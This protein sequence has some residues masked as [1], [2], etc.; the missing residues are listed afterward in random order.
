MTLDCP[1]N[2]EASLVCPTCGVSFQRQD[3]LKRHVLLH[4]GH[5]PFVCS[6]CTRRFPRRDTLQRHL[7]THQPA[8]ARQLD[9]AAGKG[10][11]DKACTSCRDSK[12]RCNGALPCQRCAKKQQP[13]SYPSRQP[14]PAARAR[15][16]HV[17]PQPQPQQS[18]A[19]STGSGGDTQPPSYR[20]TTDS[21]DG[22]SLEGAGGGV[23]SPA[24]QAE[25]TTS[26][27]VPWLQLPSLDPTALPWS[28]HTGP[29]AF[30][31]DFEVDGPPFLSDWA[32]PDLRTIFSLFP[33]AEPAQRRRESTFPHSPSAATGLAPPAHGSGAPAKN[34]GP[35][36][37]CPDIATAGIDLEDFAN[38][39]TLPVAVY[40]ATVAWIQSLQSCETDLADGPRSTPNSEATLKIPP[41]DLLNVFVQL[42]FEYFHDCLPILHLPTFD[43]GIAPPLMLLAIARI[44]SRLSK[45]PAAS[46]Y[47]PSLERLVQAGVQSEAAKT[48]GLGGEHQLWLVQ[49]AILAHFDAVFG[50]HRNTLGKA[51]ANGP[52]LG[53]LRQRLDYQGNEANSTG[54]ATEAADPDPSSWHEWIELEGTRRTAFAL[55]MLDSQCNLLLDLP[56]S[57]Q[58]EPLGQLPCHEDIWAAPN[59]DIWSDRWK[60]RYHPASM[61]SEMGSIYRGNQLPDGI[62]A[63]SFLLLLLCFFRDGQRLKQAWEIGLPA[64]IAKDGYVI[65]YEETLKDLKLWEIL[66]PGERIGEGPMDSVIFQTYQLV[67][68]LNLVPLQDLYSFCGWDGTTRRA[69]RRRIE[70]RQEAWIASNRGRKARTVA[71]RAGRLYSYCLARG[72]LT[73][74]YLE[75]RSMLIA[76]LA[77][78][79]YVSA[80]L[81]P[82]RGAGAGPFGRCAT[83]PDAEHD[84]GGGVRHHQQQQQQL[85]EETRMVRLDKPV[86]DS[87]TVEDWVTNGCHFRCFVGGLGNI[88]GRKHLRPVMIS[89][90][91]DYCASL[92]H[93]Q[94]GP[95]IAKELT[96]WHE[97]AEAC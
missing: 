35:A 28:P 84:D 13:C 26:G 88:H 78:W 7:A 63:F 59:A 31:A 72:T 29:G 71:L 66:N 52:T 30:S 2:E 4:D 62:G 24:R 19:A 53:H 39:P 96:R 67:V 11:S 5:K 94:V 85:H 92:Q 89:N 82:D 27:G 74:G 40:D 12:Q 32:S 41:R 34:S 83:T 76:T 55:W 38:V 9:T 73:R 25:S 70:A 20:H 43:P 64:M 87:R 97:C 90:A 47:G 58:T 93:W 8:E 68:V 61:R 45:I 54:S 15:Q 60:R 86:V 17:S 50:N 69:G 44:G 79:A 3:H 56:P 91:A 36:P 95:A 37:P 33:D 80:P 6:F 81:T 10:R 42:Y 18:P 49:A 21:A 46:S 16:V 14:R 57:I 48:A 75:P 1:D 65:N 22:T 23:N 51:L 77:L